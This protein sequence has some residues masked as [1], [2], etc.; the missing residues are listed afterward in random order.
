MDRWNIVTTLNYLDPEEEMAIVL[1][2][3]PDYD[4]KEERRKIQAMVAT[5]ELT[6]AGFVAGDISISSA[7]QSGEFVASHEKY[8]RNR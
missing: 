4:T 5:A 6:R 3:C 7:G 8:G 2:K 1:A